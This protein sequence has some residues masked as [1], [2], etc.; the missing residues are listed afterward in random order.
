MMVM[1]I[2]LHCTVRTMS[3]TWS[4]HVICSDTF[5]HRVNQQHG[6]YKHEF[7]LS[8]LKPVSSSIRY[9]VGSPYCSQ[10]NV[11]NIIML[12]PQPLKHKHNLHL[13]PSHGFPTLP[14]PAY[15]GPCLTSCLASSH[16]GLLWFLSI[17]PPTTVFGDAPLFPQP[18][19]LLI[20]ALNSKLKL[21]SHPWPSASHSS[22]R[23]GWLSFRGPTLVW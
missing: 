17:F 1:I 4:K 11:N 23:T 2:S 8:A 15:S 16:T 12:P 13:T 3:K 19:F 22:S 18:H 20:V 21:T 9:R 10:N 14:S 5:L 7:F 6:D